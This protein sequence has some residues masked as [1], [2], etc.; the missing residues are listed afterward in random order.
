MNIKTSF[1]G[2]PVDLE[3]RITCILAKQDEGWKLVHFH[4]SVPISESRNLGM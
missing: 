3:C 4:Y 1:L 2:S